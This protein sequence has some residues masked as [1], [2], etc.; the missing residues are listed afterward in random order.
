MLIHFLFLVCFALELV[1][2]LPPSSDFFVSIISPSA[3]LPYSIMATP[4]HSSHS[5][6]A[7]SK[8]SSYSSF[9]IST[10]M[11]GTPLFIHYIPPCSMIHTGVI[12]SNSSSISIPTTSSTP[13]AVSTLSPDISNPTPNTSLVI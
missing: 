11:P 2:G 13:T 10:L 6:M 1:Y 9:S 7:S 4:T 5:I 8:H 12:S 3:T